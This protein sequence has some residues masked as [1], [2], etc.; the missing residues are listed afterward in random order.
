MVSETPLE[1]KRFW[2]KVIITTP[3]K[4]WIWI[5]EKAKYGYG[6][7]KNGPKKHDR[8]MA[9]RVAYFLTFGKIKEGYK[10]L[11]KCDNPPCCNPDHLYQGTQKQ[12]ACDMVSRGRHRFA[13]GVAH[14]N[15]KLSD[16]QVAQIRIMYAPGVVS[17]KKL[18][19]LFSVSERLIYNII[20]RKSWKHIS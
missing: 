7:F 8:V 3:D 5:G 18:S 6:R 11:H 19:K 4:C 15:A 2:S 9:H 16:K 1:I 10:I 13:K 12:N 14:P 17:H 20:H